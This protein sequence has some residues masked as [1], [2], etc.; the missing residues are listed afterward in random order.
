[1]KLTAELVPKTVWYESLFKLLP[2]SVWNSI[3]DDIIDK[4]GKKCQICGETDGT[5][6]LH[7]IWSY[8]DVNHVQKLDGF[9]LLCTMCHHVKHIGLAGIL[10]RQGKLDYSEV[11]KHSCEVNSCSERD[12]KK[13][14]EKAFEIWRERSKY[15]WKQDFGKYERFIGNRNRQDGQ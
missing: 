8:D 9:I 15:Q 2:R 14:V 3:R 13:H 7:E 4:N 1:L 12:F 6:N 10:A 5:M 11:M